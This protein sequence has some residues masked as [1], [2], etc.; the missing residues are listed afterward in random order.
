MKN[1]YFF[2]LLISLLIIY[3]SCNIDRSSKPSS[4]GKPGELVIVIKKGLDTTST[5]L[6]IKEYFAQPLKGLPQDEPVFTLAIVN[7]NAFTTVLQRHRNILRTE[8]KPGAKAQVSINNDVW[9]KDQLMIQVIAP[10]ENSLIKILEGNH[11]RFIDYFTDRELERLGEYIRKNKDRNISDIL[12][13]DHQVKLNVLKGFK[14]IVNEPEHNFIWLRQ[15]IDRQ[16]GGQ[17]H[18]ISRNILVYY[19]DYVSQEQFDAVKMMSFK[20]SVTQKWIP[21][22]LPGSYLKSVDEYPDQYRVLNLNGSFAAELRG[23]WHLQ[24]D[25]M[26]GPYVSIST[27]DTV[28]NRLV[29][30]EAF[31][32]APQFDKREFVREMEAMLRSIEFTE[33]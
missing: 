1:I 16:K 22:S 33:K 30:A 2:S 7:P 24:G 20:D 10:D 29:T 11:A 18:E 8:I 6:R 9:A 25:F 5:A 32:Y 3:T 15:N 23:L 13:K 26:G 12:E 19:K 17:I 31:V 4:T 21:G 14:K 28:R 27:V